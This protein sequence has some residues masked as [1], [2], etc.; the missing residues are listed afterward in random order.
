VVTLVCFLLP[1]YLEICYIFVYKFLNIWAME[2]TFRRL[3]YS[4]FLAANLYIGKCL[5]VDSCYLDQLQ[6]VAGTGQNRCELNTA[7][8][9]NCRGGIDPNRMDCSS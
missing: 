8:Y 9:M 4:L 6:R 1:K 3:V 2:A 7:G 5:H